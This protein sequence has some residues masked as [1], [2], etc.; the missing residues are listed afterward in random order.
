MGA[1]PP[2]PIAAPAEPPRAPWRECIDTIEV[3]DARLLAAPLFR[4]SFGHPVPPMPRHYVMFYRAPEDGGRGGGQPV[5]VGYTHQLAFED[6][7]LAG[8]MCIDPAAY[9]WFP[10]WLFDA[11]KREG[12]LA[13]IIMRD[14]FATLGECP[15][16]FGH[17]GEKRARLADLRAGFVDTG[18]LHLMVHWRRPLPREEQ[19][20]LIERIA[21]IGPF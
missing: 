4:R 10:R 5:V 13:T 8:G 16:V 15:A 6:V 9:R 18:R 20:R 11:V 1:A 2:S 17:V 12:G 3:S 21:G 14:S 19:E 7:Y